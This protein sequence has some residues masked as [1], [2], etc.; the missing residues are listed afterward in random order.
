MNFLTASGVASASW[1]A[2]FLK[3]VNS[4]YEAKRR[5]DLSSAAFTCWSYLSYNSI[6][7]PSKLLIVFALVTRSFTIAFFASSYSVSFFVSEATYLD[8]SDFSAFSEA[9]YDFNVSISF[10]NFSEFAEFPPLEGL[11]FIASFEADNADT[12]FI[13][14]VAS[15][16]LLECPPFAVLLLI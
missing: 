16:R 8:N 5:F 15:E 12:A 3:F 11:L 14:E 7:F 1:G 9:N 6:T 2:L 13:G 4:F 10:R